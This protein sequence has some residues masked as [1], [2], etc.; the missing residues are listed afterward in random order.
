MKAELE[1][2]T[3]QINS[4]TSSEADR[5]IS[6]IKT[7]TQTL[8]GQIVT[9]AELASPEIK[10]GVLNSI[11]AETEIVCTGVKADKAQYLATRVPVHE[12][13]QLLEE[14]AG[15]APPEPKAK[16]NRQTCKYGQFIHGGFI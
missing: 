12:L 14:H 3:T 7:K 4:H 15:T 10:V 11:L 2:M 13:Q 1:K 8:P 16:A 9:A 6:T 5:I